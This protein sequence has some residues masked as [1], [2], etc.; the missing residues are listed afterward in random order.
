MPMCNTTVNVL[1]FRTLSLFVL[2][3]N[4]FYQGWISQNACWNSKRGSSLSDC[5]F[6]RKISNLAIMYILESIIN[7]VGLTTQTTDAKAGLHICCLH[8]TRSGFLES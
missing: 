3:E 8:A 2:S 7:G 5:F 6:R 4:N 1:K